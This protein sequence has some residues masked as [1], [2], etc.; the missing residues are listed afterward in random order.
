MFIMEEKKSPDSHSEVFKGSVEAKG[1]R[2]AKP[3]SPP[4]EE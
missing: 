1:A 4:P 2:G 3:K